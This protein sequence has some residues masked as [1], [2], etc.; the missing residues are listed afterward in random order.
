MNNYW[1]VLIVFSFV[2]SSLAMGLFSAV[3]VNSLR[4]DTK[5]MEYINTNQKAIM[6]LQKV[7]IK[8]AENELKNQ[9]K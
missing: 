5:Q 8:L 9:S 2:T 3:N 4:R 6:E 1:K 7:T